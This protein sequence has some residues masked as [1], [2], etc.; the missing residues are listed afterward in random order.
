ML[1]FLT[2]IKQFDARV[3]ELVD[4]YVWGAYRIPCVSSILISRTIKKI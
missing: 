3:A 4:A 2:I 1:R